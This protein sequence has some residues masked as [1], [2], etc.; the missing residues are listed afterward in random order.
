MPALSLVQIC[1]LVKVH[2]PQEGFRL[3]QV[4]LLLNLS[5]SQAR[6]D[7]HPYSIPVLPPYFQKLVQFYQQKWL[8]TF[9]C[10]TD[11]LM[12]VASLQAILCLQQWWSCLHHWHSL[13]QTIASDH[14]IGKNKTHATYWLFLVSVCPC[15]LFT[16]PASVLLILSHAYTDFAAKLK[17][18]TR[19]L[20]AWPI[21][22]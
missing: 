11:P 21:S 19:F 14:K 16:I 13:K 9:G 18:F 2:Q 17:L 20:Y 12:V 8:H 15:G 22:S 6:S 5:P 4:P 1:W 3:Q 7:V 10:H